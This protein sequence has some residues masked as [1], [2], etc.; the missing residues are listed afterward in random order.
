MRIRQI[1][2]AFWADATMADLPP[3]IRLTYIGLWM[4]AD[5]AGWFRESIPEIALSLYGYEP[6]SR[7]ERLVSRALDILA[8]AGRVVRH[9]CG[10]SQ[11]PTL[12]RHQRIGGKRSYIWRS[13]HNVR[14]VGA[15]S[16]RTDPGSV[17]DDPDHP[18]A[19]RDDMGR[20]ASNVTE[21]NVTSNVTERN[22]TVARARAKTTDSEFRRRMAAEG[23]V[24]EVD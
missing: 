21:R 3:E 18:V 22:G 11:I 20:S 6:R 1:T 19:I 16:V 24:L 7:R 9:E 14:C 12:E 23:V 4:V 8:T 5:D 13:E 10:H 17:R 15:G 2:P